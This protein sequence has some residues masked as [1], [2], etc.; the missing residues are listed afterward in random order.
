[1]C[2]VLTISRYPLFGRSDPAYGGDS[3][4][5]NIGKKA[6]AA[7]LAL[8]MITSVMVAGVAFSGSAAALEDPS[9]DGEFGT[10]AVV[11]STADGG[12]TGVKVRATVI[13]DGEVTGNLDEINI[14]FGQGVGANSVSAGNLK[15][16][17]IAEDGSVNGDFSGGDVTGAD[18][19]INADFVEITDIQSDVSGVTLG[20][21]KVIRFTIDTTDINLPSDDLDATVG[22][23]N[24]SGASATTDVTLQLNPGPVQVEGG[25]S[26]ST[27]NQ[28]LTDGNLADD[29]AN[30]ITVED[31]LFDEASN[32]L[33][34]PDNVTIESADGDN[35]NVKILSG[36]DLQSN[37]FIDAIQ[38][39]DVTIRDLRFDVR[40]DATSSNS[41]EN[42]IDSQGK[43]LTLNNNVVN[44]SIN[45]LKD[46]DD[47]HIVR[48]G[49]QG[50][51]SDDSGDVLTNNVFRGSVSS[52]SGGEQLLA[53]F[54]ETNDELIEDNTFK[55]D[56]GILESGG[57]TTSNVTIRNNNFDV[58]GFAIAGDASDVLIDNNDIEATSSPSSG[59]VGLLGGDNITLQDN[60]IDGLSNEF[61]NGIDLKSGQNSALGNVTITGNSIS[62][63][64]TNGLLIEDSSNFQS[65]TDAITV[66]DL[67]VDNANAGGGSDTG[68]TIDIDSSNLPDIDISASSINATG[69]GIDVQN[70]G[71]F[72]NVSSTSVDNTGS[73]SQ[74]INLAN[75][76]ADVNIDSGTSIDQADTGIKVDVPGSNSI[77]VTNV[78][79]NGTSSGVDLDTVGNNGDT[80]V[81]VTD[82]TFT[83]NDPAAINV[84]TSISSNANNNPGLNVHFNTFESNAVGI[85]FDDSSYQSTFNAT[86]NDFVDNNAQGL[87]VQ[88]IDSDDGGVVNANYS[89]WDN[90]DSSRIV[91]P[92]TP[93]NAGSQ[94]PIPRR[95][96]SYTR[97]HTGGQP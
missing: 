45:T 51:G 30:T 59:A 50:P 70:A 28:A 1:M 78:E 3:M 53:V 92:Y 38:Q 64:T 26:Y 36:N 31:G 95:V 40:V 68:V 19:T 34:V 93:Q 96:Y 15:V 75:A 63:V 49:T 48:L 6:R 81:N 52:V 43:N 72:V 97:L 35:A 14:S 58:A 2:C 85:G 4:N 8:I 69:T 87:D 32:S 20:D 79:I 23:K 76:G 90:R 42:V 88:G 62:N 60:T 25:N 86:F 11:D 39:T 55:T 65:N 82:S 7:F 46:A 10:L 56:D 44:V 94:L 54:T 5:G 84:S 83:N 33:N 12:E 80:F 77:E 57:A 37:P 13:Q 22:I 16:D 24:N 18:V 61:T 21:K 73:G 66:S 9:N 91:G 41:I 67:T 29:T 17:V 47:M 71:A 89:W 74:A 27:L